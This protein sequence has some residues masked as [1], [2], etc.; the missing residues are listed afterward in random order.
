MRSLR[1]M[2]HVDIILSKSCSSLHLLQTAIVKK[3]KTPPSPT[4]HVLLEAFAD[5]NPLQYV[6]IKQEK[7]DTVRHGYKHISEER[8]GSKSSLIELGKKKNQK[9]T[10]L[11][12]YPP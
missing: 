1:G 11:A 5:D 7:P 10:Q 3:K 2:S 9:T 8:S 6:P 12:Y 4:L